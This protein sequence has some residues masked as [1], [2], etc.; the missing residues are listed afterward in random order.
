[1]DPDES[2]NEIVPP[3]PKSPMDMY[4]VINK[5]V[6]PG[7]F[8][9]VHRDF[10][11]NIIVGFSRIDGI[12]NGIIANQP[13][14]QSGAIDI[15]ASDK[16]ARFIR[17][18][19]AF[20][21]P[22]INLV[23]VPG[24]MPGVAQEQGGIIRHGAKMLFAYAAATVP[25]ITVIARRAYG[26]SYL[27]MCSRDL[28]ADMVFAWPNAEIAVMGAEG[29]V[30]VLYR[31]ELADDVEN[32]ETVRADKIAEYRERF[33]SP[34]M[35]ASHGMIT[36]VIEPAQTRCVVSLALRNTLTKSEYRPPKKHGLIPL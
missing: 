14:V 17:F 22:I 8:L 20:N 29:A 35:A 12:V 26:G 9:E 10:A 19:N 30:D 16:A 27:A 4:E 23:D 3:D 2:M 1:M 32:R 6:D 18:C 5:L 34:Y 33:A 36:D 24:F 13:M 28:R 7:T 11:M 21:I 31:K 25:K 15:D